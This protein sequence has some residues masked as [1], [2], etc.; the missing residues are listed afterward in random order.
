MLWGFMK[1]KMDWSKAT[2]IQD[3]KEQPIHLGKLVSPAVTDSLCQSFSNHV[4]IARDAVGQ[5]IQPLTSNHTTVMPPE[6]FPDRR[7]FHISLH[8]R[9]RRTGYLTNF[10]QKRECEN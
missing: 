2:N 5:I 4:K 8:G 7:K 10:A 6:Y 9:K 1:P 3:A